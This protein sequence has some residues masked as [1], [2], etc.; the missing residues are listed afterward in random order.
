MGLLAGFLLLHAFGAH[1]SYNST[2]FDEWMSQLFGTERDNYD[3]LVHFS[4]GLLCAYPIREALRAWT[5]LGQQMDLCDDVCYR[6]G[7]GGFL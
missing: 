1:Y 2:G 7:Y 5:S 3:R 6:F 4:F